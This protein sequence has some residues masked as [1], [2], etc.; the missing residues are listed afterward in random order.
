MKRYMAT[1]ALVV[2]IPISASD[3]REARALASAW[4]GESSMHLGTEGNLDEVGFDIEGSID[5]EEV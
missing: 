2:S 3:R 5:V 1:A 4:F